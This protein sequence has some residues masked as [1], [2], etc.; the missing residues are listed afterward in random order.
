MGDA[1]CVKPNSEWLVVNRVSDLPRLQ[2]SCNAAE[3]P[4]EFFVSLC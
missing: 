4:P 2:L 1:L 3:P